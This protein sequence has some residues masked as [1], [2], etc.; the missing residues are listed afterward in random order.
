[1]APASPHGLNAVEAGEFDDE[2]DVG[3][4]VVVGTSGD[5]DY[6]VAHADVFGIRAG[7]E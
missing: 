3:V 1:M 7:K 2:G 5:V 6:D 4:V